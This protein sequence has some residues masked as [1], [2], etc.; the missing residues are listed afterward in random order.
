MDKWIFGQRQLSV[1]L[2]DGFE[3]QDFPNRLHSQ[4]KPGQRRKRTAQYLQHAH[5]Q[6]GRRSS[7]L[8][9]R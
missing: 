5:V 7:V 2:N 6:Q 8:P 9:Q 4:C 3:K 1:Q